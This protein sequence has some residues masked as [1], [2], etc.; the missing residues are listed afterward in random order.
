MIPLASLDPKQGLPLGQHRA[1]V[2]VLG[3]RIWVWVANGADALAA[4]GGA[5]A[6]REGVEVDE[7]R[8]VGV[9]HGGNG[10]AHQTLLA[11][12]LEVIDHVGERRGIPAQA[13]HLEQ[14][15]FG[16]HGIG[17]GAGAFGTVENLGV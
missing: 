13:A 3:Y 12:A 16:G 10:A 17:G 15:R 1:T 2:L 7:R 14:P 6:H 4:L 9:C 5:A 8:A 11:I